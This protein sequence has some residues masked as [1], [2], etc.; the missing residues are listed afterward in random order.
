MTVNKE[1]RN[2]EERRGCAANLLDREGNMSKVQNMHEDVT[3]KPL[4]YVIS[5]KTSKP[6]PRELRLSFPHKDTT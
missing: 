2:T 6:T 4:F 3:R 5:I 1:D